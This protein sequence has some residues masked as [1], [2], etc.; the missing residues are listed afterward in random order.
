MP[1]SSLPENLAREVHEETGLAITVGAPVLIN[2]FHAPER[3]FHQIDVYFRCAP[4]GHM[5]ESWTDP[6]GIV[7]ERR[8]FSRSEL[9]TVRYKPD[10]LPDAA[11]GSGSMLYDPLELLVR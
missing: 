3:D 1:H 2:E 4:N 7:T 11:W 8:F 5:P 9:A 10:S 6:A